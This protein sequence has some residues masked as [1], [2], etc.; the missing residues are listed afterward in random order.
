VISWDNWKPRTDAIGK[1][2]D[3]QDTLCGVLM[4]GTTVAW[5]ISVHKG[6]SLKNVG[7]NISR[8]EE[9]SGDEQDFSK[10]LNGVADTISD[11]AIKA[12]VVDFL[13]E[14]LYMIIER[15]ERENGELG[16]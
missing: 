3:N 10:I 7:I 1:R 6:G 4:T 9:Y 15:A 12:A 13:R 16:K 14:K 5:K 8:G 11:D 2:V